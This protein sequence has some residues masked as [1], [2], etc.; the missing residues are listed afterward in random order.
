MLRVL[1]MRLSKTV[2][3]CSVWVREHIV[4]VVRMLVSGY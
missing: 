4:H 1:L 2:S 3:G